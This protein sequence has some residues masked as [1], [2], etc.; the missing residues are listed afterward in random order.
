[1]SGEETGSGLIVKYETRPRF[2]HY[3]LDTI[4]TRH[5][6]SPENADFLYEIRD[7]LFGFGLRPSNRAIFTIQEDTVHVLTVHRSAQ[8]TLRAEDI[9]FD[10][11]E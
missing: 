8:D 10:P 4:P 11:N 2:L 9:A 3:S 6:L 5:G 1:V 7:L